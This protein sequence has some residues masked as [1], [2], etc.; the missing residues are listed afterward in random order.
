MDEKD[1][2]LMFPTMT[3]VKSAPALFRI[4][5]CGLAMYGRR[6]S[7][8]ETGTY[9]STWCACLLFIPVFALRAY[10]VADAEN[11]GQYFIGREALS[12]L[13]KAFNASLIAAIAIG[14][15]AYQYA[16]YTSTPAYKARQQMAA[17]AKL[18]QQGRLAE[19]ARTYESL[20]VTDTTEKENAINAI[21]ALINGPAQQA[22]LGEAAGVFASATKVA[23]RGH[24]LPPTEASE[25]AI[26]LAT[27]RGEADPRG[28]VAVLDA[29]V[30]LVLDT[31]AVDEKRLHFLRA[32]AAR[33]PQNLEVIVPLASLLEAQGRIDEAA[34][35]LTP[36]QRQ[37]ADGEGARVLGTV[38]SRQG[39]YEGAYALLWPY[40]K[41]RLDALRAAEKRSADTLD[42][43]WDRE[44][45]DLRQN[46]GPQSFYKK[47]E[48]AT[49]AQ[50]NALVQEY[51][52][53]RLR[54]HPEYVASQDALEQAARIVPV[55][56][57]LG[58]VLVQR[59]QAQSTPDARKSQLESAEQIFLAISGI[60]SESDKYRITLGQVYYW[61]G[62]P[63]EGRKLFDEYM[64]SNSRSARSMMMIAS[65]LRQVGLES[66]ARKLA[67]QSYDGATTTEDKHDAA[68]LRAVCSVDE[69]DEIEW[70]RKSNTE[71]P[72]VKAS[73]EKA[74]GRQARDQGRDQDAVKHYTAAI[75]AYGA[76]PRS[77]LTLNETALAYA[78]IYYSGG[79]PQSI[80]R[81]VDHFQQALDLEPSDTILLI[82]AASTILSA[83]MADVIGNEIDLRALRRSG[84]FD[85]LRFLYEDD[86]GRAAV[87][88]RLKAHPGVTRAM[89]YYDKVLVLAPKNASGYGML[90]R[91]YRFT[92]DEAALRSLDAKLKGAELDMSDSLERLKESLSGA[93]DAQHIATAQ[94]SLK[95]Y[96]ERMASVRPAGGRTAGVAV[97]DVA[98]QML[99]LY[100]LGVE[101][102]LDEAVRLAEEARTLAPCSSTTQLL[103][104]ARLGRVGRELCNRDADFKAFWQQYRRVLDTSRLLAVALSRPGPLRDR[105][106]ENAEFIA[107]LD[108]IKA[109]ATKFVGGYGPW[110]WAML[111]HVDEAEARKAADRVRAEPRR[112]VERSIYASLSPASVSDAIDAY[113]LMQIHSRPEE[114]KAAL[115]RLKALSL[116]VPPME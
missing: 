107:T 26:K 16:E 68:S 56:L 108:L 19:A 113:W 81:C 60:A 49:E 89:S 3:P 57:E 39:D 36:V 10:R 96:R 88:G 46:K 18:E 32:L 114:A 38:L 51:V 93:K 41:G 21:R 103:I 73:L 55:A 2:K 69:G 42:R 43:L 6:D 87:V 23:R 61:L 52:H 65:Q 112:E 9:I 72:H 4:N 27:A 59:A 35:L 22:A 30:P 84:E 71:D 37:L 33:E 106:L 40:V 101:V 100:W 79:D 11:G 77:S 25:L 83:A 90:F 74:L 15:G 34:D 105:V 5:G 110:E 14:L 98:E 95:R 76:M 80:G 78:G 17:A 70:L 75:A 28:A 53:G 111:R 13:A 8:A 63:A 20:V 62:K 58:T 82:N 31:R 48:S 7:H 94:A 64:E 45:D 116:P 67:E 50:R 92:K 115:D 54:G 85:L 66:E 47:L 1:L 104:A 109:D 29:I 86:D 102:D 99:G 91:Y 24:G 44:V 97:A 12:G